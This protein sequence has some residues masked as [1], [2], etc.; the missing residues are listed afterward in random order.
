MKKILIIISFIGLALTLLPSFLV[1]ANAISWDTY[2]L[3]MNVGTIMWFVSAPF[4][5]EKKDEA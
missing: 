4:W 2:L 5:M 3:L 1:F